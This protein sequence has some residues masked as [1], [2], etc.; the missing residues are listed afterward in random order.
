MRAQ[1]EAVEQERDGARKAL[2]LHGLLK[3][4]IHMKLDRLV[5]QLAP[6]NLASSVDPDFEVSLMRLTQA[7]KVR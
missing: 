3:M 1:C 7:V 5:T 6:E 4:L 2:A